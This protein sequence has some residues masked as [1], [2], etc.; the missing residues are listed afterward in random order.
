MGKKRRTHAVNDPLLP[1]F[2]TY[3][4]SSKRKV[5]AIISKYLPRYGGL[6]KFTGCA[7]KT[8]IEYLHSTNLSFKDEWQE[9]KLT[10][11]NHIKTTTSHVGEIIKSWCSGLIRL[12]LNILVYK[13][14]SVVEI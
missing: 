14:L 3:F 10:Q 12:K 1:P 5:K 8:F 11:E 2:S 9:K 13:T 4:P 7:G 6:P